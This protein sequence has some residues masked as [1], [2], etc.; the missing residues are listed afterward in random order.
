[1]NLPQD[2]EEFIA[3]RDLREAEVPGDRRLG[4][5]RYDRKA[6]LGLF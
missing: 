4:F 1:M 6:V 5:N 2:F 3:P